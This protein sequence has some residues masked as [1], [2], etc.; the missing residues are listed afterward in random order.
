MESKKNLKK[1]LGLILEEEEKQVK[2]KVEDLSEIDFDQSIDDQPVNV[3]TKSVIILDDDTKVKATGT[4][5]EKK[6]H[7][8]DIHDEDVQMTKQQEQEPKRGEEKQTEQEARV[9]T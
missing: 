5:E 4:K 8:E 3:Q 9:I 2:L 6:D 1:L 7:T